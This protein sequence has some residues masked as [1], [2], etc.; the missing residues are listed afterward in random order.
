M[1]AVLPL[2]WVVNV[3]PPPQISS[4]QET[5]IAYWPGL[6][7]GNVFFGNSGR[8]YYAALPQIILRINCGIAA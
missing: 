6:A 8:Q 2:S 1:L 4:E 7:L 3:D 5:P